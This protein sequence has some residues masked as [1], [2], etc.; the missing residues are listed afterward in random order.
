MALFILYV[1]YNVNFLPLLLSICKAERHK[2]CVNVMSS[3]KKVIVFSVDGRVLEIQNEFV[4]C[5][6]KTKKKQSCDQVHYNK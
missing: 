4:H 2:M 5:K 1:G 6:N 3:L